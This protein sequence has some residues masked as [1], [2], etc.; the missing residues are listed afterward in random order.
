LDSHRPAVAGV[1]CS[2]GKPVGRDVGANVVG[3]TMGG[4][5]LHASGK[6]PQHP[7][8]VSKRNVAWAVR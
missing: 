8:L 4:L 5:V 1:G 2:V 3:M 6:A 7:S